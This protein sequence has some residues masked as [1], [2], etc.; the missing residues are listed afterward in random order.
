MLYHRT[1]HQTVGTINRMSTR[2]A[3]TFD[4]E[5]DVNGAFLNPDSRA[6]RGIESLIGNKPEQALGLTKA[7]AI[8]DQY[9]FPATFFIETTQAAYFGLDEMLHAVEMIAESGHELQ[10]H[11]H[12]VWTVFNRRDW[13][14][15]VLQNPPQSNREDSFPMQDDSVAQRLLEEGFRAF[16]YWGLPVPTAVR[17]GSLFIEPNA[18]KHFSAQQL[19]VSSSVGLGLNPPSSDA[20]KLYQGAKELNGVLELPVTSYLGYDFL[21]RKKI[22]LATLIGMGTMEQAALLKNAEASGV[23]FVIL[24]SHASEFYHHSDEQGYRPNRLTE[25]KLEQLCA[26][27]K[28]ATG[29]EAATIRDL[30][31][32]KAHVLSKPDMALNVPALHSLAR[33]PQSLLN[34]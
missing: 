19:S 16:E 12:P 27:V 34:R 28:H 13:Q 6:P 22:R 15:A 18:Y 23:P 14:T 8:L 26:T 17:T 2:V 5:F 25:R 10:L 7:L 11:V 32:T 21:C 30:Q 4:I 29:L 20:L 24:L 3:L 1:L 33:F 9:E 31:N